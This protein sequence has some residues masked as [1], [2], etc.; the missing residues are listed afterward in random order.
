MMLHRLTGQNRL[1]T[2]GDVVAISKFSQLQVAIVVLTLLV[3]ALAIPARGS[4]GTLASGIKSVFYTPGEALLFS[5]Y[6]NTYFV[7]RDSSGGISWNGTLEE[8]ESKHLTLGEGIYSAT[9]SKPYTVIVG[10]SQT[11]TVVGYYAIDTFGKGTSKNIYTFIPTRD[12]LYPQSQFIIFSYA[13]GTVVKVTDARSKMVLWQGILNEG[14]HFNEDLGNATWQN[15]TVR[16]EST[17]PVSALCYLDQGFIV[18]SSMGLFTGTLFYTFA[19]NIT[20]GNNDLNVIGYHDNTWVKIS[21]STSKSSVWNGTLSAGEVHSE[22][23]AKPTF[24][25]IESNQ[26]VA[27]TVDP[28]PTWPIMYN[29]ALYAG[30]IDG[31]LIGKNF[32]AT[33]RGGGYLRII[34][35]QND[36]HVTVTDQKTHT[37]VWDGTLD[38]MKFHTGTTSHTVYNVTSDKPVSVLEGYGEWSAMFAPLYYATDTEPPTIGTLSRTPQNPTPTQDVRIS[39][40]VSDDL[41]G[42]Q[43]VILSYNSGGVG[44]AN[45]NMTLSGGNTYVANIPAMPSQTQ[46]NYRIVAYDNMGNVATSGTASYVVAGYPTGSIVINGGETYTASPSVTLTLTYNDASAAVSQVRYSN[47]GTWDTEQWESPSPSK[48]WSLTQGDGTKTVYYQVSNVVGMLSPTYSDSITLDT[49]P[50]AATITSPSEGQKIQ[51]STVTVAWSG[52]DGGSGIEKYEVKLDSGSWLS[53]GVLT[54]HSFTNVS[55]GSHTVYLKA[56]DNAGNSKEYTRSFSIITSSPNETDRVAPTVSVT[57]RLSHLNK[58]QT[59][60]FTVVASDDTDGSGIANVTLFVD[61]VAVKT[62]TTAG[63][64]T[65]SSGP[66][67]EGVHTFYVEAFD[68]ANN[69]GRDPTIG[70]KEFIVSSEQMQPPITLWALL[71]FVSVAAAAIVAGLLIWKRKSDEEKRASDHGRTRMPF[72]HYSF[73]TSSPLYF[74]HDGVLTSVLVSADVSSSV[75][76]SIT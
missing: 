51:S 41:S 69:K 43:K 17:F 14:E 15:R 73:S 28:Y 58:T 63:T 59:A 32:F 53:K 2:N 18:P 9:G 42:V 52:S 60:A 12:P 45:L 48:T 23:F 3:A 75:H 27:V 70:D 36:T 11:E 50:P 64:H 61:G 74:S 21:D 10:T 68:N 71:I 26:S 16:V 22:V 62:W 31:N 34:A 49:T 54:T 35:Y 20:N 57:I 13:N 55:N 5:Y 39:V 40:E 47:D 25:T 44:W 8:G 56:T 37:S 19:G 7:L 33:A 72:F 24:L 65:Y 29:A 30:E 6:N 4:D 67:T 38:E 66:Y 1:A 76:L 46:V